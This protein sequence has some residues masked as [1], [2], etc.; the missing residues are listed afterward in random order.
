MPISVIIAHDSDHM[1][2][3]RVRQA[4]E[5][6]DD[7][8]VIGEALHGF[9]VLDRWAGGE[10]IPKIVLLDVSV[11]ELDGLEAIRRIR[12]EHPYVEVIVMTVDKDRHLLVEAVR[13]KV[14]GYLWK[15]VT[16]E[17]LIPTIRMVAD[18]KPVIDPRFC[19]EI[20]TC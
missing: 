12:D 6:A 10:A 14:T 9:D 4:L 19:P 2:R 7:I 8:Q 20:A 15:T 5:Q 16:A 17:D 11:P 18:G 1:V 13:A 3:H